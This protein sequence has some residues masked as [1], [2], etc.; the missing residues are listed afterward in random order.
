MALRPGRA[1]AQILVPDLYGPMMILLT[2][3]AV[4][5]FGMKSGGVLA[6]QEGTLIGTAFAAAFGYW[7]SASG[8]GPGAPL[9]CGWLGGAAGRTHAGRVVP[10][11][12]AVVLFSIAFIFNTT[13]NMTEMLSLVVRGGAGLGPGLTA[14]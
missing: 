11:G 12:A 13:V 14:N 1:A 3:V 7:I 5:L 8:A 4:L 10:V 6:A 9:R 2:L